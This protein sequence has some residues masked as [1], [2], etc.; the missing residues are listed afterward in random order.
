MKSEDTAYCASEELGIGQVSSG[1]ENEI[2][3]I[4]VLSSRRTL[5]EYFSHN[6]H[7]HMSVS[8]SLAVDPAEHV[9]KIL[10]RKPAE[11]AGPGSRF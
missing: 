2:W 10:R 5:G 8:D 1:I 6:C 4:S 3:G 9:L 7:S 11:P